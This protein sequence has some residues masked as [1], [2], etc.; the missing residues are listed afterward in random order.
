MKIVAEF[1]RHNDLALWGTAKVAQCS[2]QLRT[3]KILNDYTHMRSPGDFGDLEWLGYV[4]YK[5]YYLKFPCLQFV[6]YQTFLGVAA[7]TQLKD[8]PLDGFSL[9][10]SNI[11]QKSGR[12]CQPRSNNIEEAVGYFWQTIFNPYDNAW[13]GNKIVKDLGGYQGWEKSSRL[14]PNWVPDLS[15]DD[16]MRQITLGRFFF[17]VSMRGG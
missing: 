16:E 14:D 10:L 12:I 7:I 13:S 3:V 2:P 11:Y 5:T 15:T 17:D 1:D 9:P 8:E 6:W 4:G